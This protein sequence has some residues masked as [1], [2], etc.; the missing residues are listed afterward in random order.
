VVAA[1]E[2]MAAEAAVEEGAAEEANF[3][4]ALLLLFNKSCFIFTQIE[5]R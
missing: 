5:L 3:K 1:E 4:N 2:E